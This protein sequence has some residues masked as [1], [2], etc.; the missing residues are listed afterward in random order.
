MAT[1]KIYGIWT[2][3]NGIVVDEVEF[4]G[5]AH[6]FAIYVDGRCVITIYADS[7]EQ[8]EEMRARLDAGED[9][10]DWEDGDG[11]CVWT[12]IAEDE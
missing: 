1:E 4:D 12:L 11:D 3:A 6:A 8:T 5:D 2:Q 10:R 9:V 7:P